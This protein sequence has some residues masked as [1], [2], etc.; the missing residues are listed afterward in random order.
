MENYIKRG[1]KINVYWENIK[2]EF[3]LTVISLPEAPGDWFGCRREDGTSINVG[4][5]CKMEQVK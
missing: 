2:A 3:N 1:D 4:S 5:F